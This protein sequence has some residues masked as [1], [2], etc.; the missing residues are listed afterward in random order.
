MAPAKAEWWSPFRRS[1][2]CPSNSWVW[3]SNRTICNHS[4]PANSRKHYLPGDRLNTQAS[5]SKDDRRFSR[6]ALRLARRG[7]GLTSPNPMVGAVLVKSGKTIGLGWHHAAGQP[8]AEIEAIRDAHRRAQS[9]KGST[10]YVT[11]EPCCTHGLT[12]PCTDA[13]IS[14]QIMRLV[15]GSSDPN[16]LHC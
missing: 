2:G 5:F 13:I 10:L 14:A 16:P 3:V 4:T 7:Y 1:S 11:L 15:A 8:H 6:M 9:T 12:P